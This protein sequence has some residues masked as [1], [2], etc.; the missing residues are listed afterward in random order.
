[1]L[2]IETYVRE[3]QIK[4]FGFRTDQEREWFR[5]LQ[6]VQGVG[7]KVAL[8]VLGT[9]FA[10]GGNAKSDDATESGYYA[11]RAALAL[12]VALHGS[13]HPGA[14]AVASALESALGER[15]PG[16]PVRTAWTVPTLIPQARA[17]SRTESPWAAMWA[18]RDAATC[19][20]ARVTAASSASVSGPAGP[21]SR[22]SMRSA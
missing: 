8:A 18:S 13:P 9:V 20:T 4:L 21:S 6:T 14:A 17:T 3:D 5:L 19:C 11:V 12:V 16:V 1:M 22:A 2:S 7:A 10:L 15:L